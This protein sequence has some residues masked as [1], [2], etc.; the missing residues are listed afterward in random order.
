MYLTN[1][2]IKVIS[3]VAFDEKINSVNPKNRD[4]S[5]E[6]YINLLNNWIQKTSELFFSLP[7]WK[8]FNTRNWNEYKIL[9][10]KFFG[11]DIR[12]FC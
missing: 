9:S 4:K 6:Y 5:S 12:L 10:D 1:K 8:Y 2:L 7:T 3:Q 11:R